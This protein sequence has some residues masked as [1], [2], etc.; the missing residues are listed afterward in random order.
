MLAIRM[1][2]ANENGFVLTT[3]L[4]FLSIIALVGG[5]AYITTNTDMKIGGNYKI[6]TQVQFF[7]EAGIEEARARLRLPSTDNNRIEDPVA[8]YDPW[9][10]AYMLSDNS[11]QT[12]DDPGYDA[13]YR[14]YIPTTADQT[15]STAC[16]NSLQA[17]LQYGVKI[18]HKR[19]YD[20]EKLGHTTTATHYYDGD[21]DTSGNNAGSPG[22]IIYYGYG[23]PGSPNTPT[24]F[25][26]SGA[27]THK[28]IDIITGYGTSGNSIRAIEA[29][30]VTLPPPPVK[31]ALYAKGN[32]TGNGS[33]LSVD[34]ADNCGSAAPLPPIY[35]LA[36]ASTTLNGIPTMNGNPATPVNGASSLDIASYINNLKD[37]ATVTITS[38]QSNVSYGTSTGFVNCYSDTSNPNNVGGL[39]LQNITGYGVLLVEGDLVLGGGFTWNGVILCSGVLTFNGGGSGVNIRGAVLA[40]QT[41]SINGG[42]DIRYDS[43]LIDNAFD[44]QPRKVISW[45]QV[46]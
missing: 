5:T 41:V 24:Q 4:I 12:T 38:D 32:V 28:P 25:S 36:P 34:G 27:T 46:Y 16:I 19:E 10:S 2:H 29:E 6:A 44:T 18:R 11:W 14:N 8:G 9:W 7:A 17:T 39:K 37:A 22:S 21:G 31:S 33:A 30:V 23:D 42:L 15:N 26:I 3:A 40:E 43:C 45:R 13:N 35:T 1:I 20:A